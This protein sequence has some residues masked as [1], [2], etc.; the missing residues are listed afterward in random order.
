M[1]PPRYLEPGDTV[2][3]EIEGLGAV[4]HSIVKQT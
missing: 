2:R 3:V 1:G 4:E